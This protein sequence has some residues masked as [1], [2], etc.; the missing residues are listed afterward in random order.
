MANNIFVI[1][2]GTSSTSTRDAFYIRL[3]GSGVI[4]GNFEDEDDK[5]K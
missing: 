1:G 3:D 4:E 5:N 2:A